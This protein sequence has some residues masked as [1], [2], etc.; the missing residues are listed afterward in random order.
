L[1]ERG[2]ALIV[3]INYRLGPLGFLALPE[4]D[5]ARAAAP[6]GLDGIRDQQLALEWVKGNAEKFHGDPANV[7]V[8]GESAG[9]HSACVHL[10]SPKSRGLAQRFIMQSGFLCTVPDAVATRAQAY[11]VG[12][13]LARSFCA[14]GGDLVD[15]LRRADAN[16]LAAWV[17]ATP[18]NQ[19]G[20]N[21][22]PAVDGPAGVLPEHPQKLV[23]EGHYDRS[24]AIIAG[25][26]Q[27]EWGLFDS[28]LYTPTT[29]VALEQA[30]QNRYGPLAPQIQAL[31]P[32]R[33]DADAQRVF[34]TLMTDVLMR[35]RTRDLA[36]ATAAHGTRFFLY[37]YEVG[38]AF[39]VDELLGL[40][41]IDF[42]HAGVSNSLLFFGATTPSV[43]FQATMQ[44][45]WTQFAATGDPNG[46]DAPV[47]PAYD[48]ATEPHLGLEDPLP[49]AGANLQKAQ[50]N[51][52]AEHEYGVAASAR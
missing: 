38:R 32:A 52:W 28:P 25:N 7:T 30:I 4:L 45:Y 48:S 8:F 27:Y 31:Y 37:Q 19:L 14:S 49:A 21:F 26:N 43:T 13:E 9:S 36:R 1:S 11:T 29:V 51:F 34:D 39:H 33:S 16:A 6:S 44:G 42:A 50:C 10:V 5:A 2:P 20:I 17:P 15:C 23:E 22:I 24:A 3:T 35:C 18:L 47:W 41:K 46:R 12:A 40:F